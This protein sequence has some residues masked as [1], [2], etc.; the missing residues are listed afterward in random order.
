MRIGIIT[1]PVK[2]MRKVIE[3]SDNVIE[4]SDSNFKETIDRYEQ[5]L[6]EAAR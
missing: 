4:L 5:V 3:M 1:K 6:K 2:N